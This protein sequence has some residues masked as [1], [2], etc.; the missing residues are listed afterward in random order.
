MRATASESRQSHPWHFQ[1]GLS[2]FGAGAGLLVGTPPRNQHGSR[3]GDRSGGGR[4][5]ASS[6]SSCP[7]SGARD[8]RGGPRWNLR[9]E[10]VRH[11]LRLMGPALIGSASGQINVLVN[12]NF[13]AGLRDASGHVMNGPVSWLAYAYRFFVLPMGVF[14]VAIASAALPRISRSAAHR[15]FAEF[16]RNAFAVDSDDP[17]ADDSGVGRSGGSRR[18]HDRHCLSAR[19]VPARTTRIRRRLRSRATRRDWR[20][21]RR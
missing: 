13:A 10:G 19:Q 5:R 14:G 16:R 6:R 1:P 15:N 12:T 20:A 9:H 11:I 2:A 21:I 4:R 8:S 18:E 17:A 7:P 3:D